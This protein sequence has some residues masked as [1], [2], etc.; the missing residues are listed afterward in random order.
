[1]LGLLLCLAIGSAAGCEVVAP[2]GAVR[3]AYETANGKDDKAVKPFTAL[4]HRDCAK[5]ESEFTEQIARDPDDQRLYPGRARALLC[6]GKYDDAIADYTRA[7]S[8]DPKWFDYFGRGLAYKAKGDS[9]QAIEN[10]DQ[11]IAIDSKVPALYVYRGAVFASEGKSAA[12]S[13]DFAK[14]QTLVSENPRRL[15][16]YA[17]RLATSPVAAYRDGPAAVLYAN[18]ACDLTTR[19]KASVMDTLAA[20]AAQNGQ[21]DDAL[22]WQRAALAADPPLD[23]DDYEARLALYEKHQPYR[24]PKVITWY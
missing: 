15:N 10:F 7:I 18:R 1:M 17:W 23:R 5:A 11:G 8:L 3:A 21:F 6:L 4:G 22:K 14:V 19:N 16:D 13:A 20:A 2:V 24:D 9:K 12:A